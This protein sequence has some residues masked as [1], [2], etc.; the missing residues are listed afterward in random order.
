MSHT[1]L[2]VKFFTLSFNLSVCADVASEDH[3]L[4]ERQFNLSFTK[5]NY[6]R[7]QFWG[8]KANCTA[9]AFLHLI[10]WIANIW[11]ADHAC[12]IEG[13]RVWH[14]ETFHQRYIYLASRT[15]NNT[16]AQRDSIMSLIVKQ[17][18][19]NKILSSVE[20]VAL[21]RKYDKDGMCMYIYMYYMD[22]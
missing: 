12:V 6:A 7:S 20:F 8:D 11:Y 16:S 22:I 2:H 10:R 4:N 21:F 19:G 9:A 1:S 15:S 14:I 5:E 3:A 17:F 13:R 18:N